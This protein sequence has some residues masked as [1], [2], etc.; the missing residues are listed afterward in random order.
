M[1]VADTYDSLIAQTDPAM[2]LRIL[3]TSSRTPSSSLEVAYFSVLVA[4][5][6]VHIEVR[7]NGRGISPESIDKVFEAFYQEQ[8]TIE[9]DSQGFGLGLAIVKRLTDA[10]GYRIKVVSQPGHGTL[11]RL[12]VPHPI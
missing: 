1:D 5:Q 9:V 7:D 11:M 4:R 8:D 3:R 2:L 12:V 6:R 10:L